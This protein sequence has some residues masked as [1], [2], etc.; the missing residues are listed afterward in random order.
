[1][2][3]NIKRLEQYGLIRRAQVRRGGGWTNT[4]YWAVYE[5]LEVAPRMG[6][7]EMAPETVTPAA[8]MAPGEISAGTSEG[9][10]GGT[11]GGALTDQS[12]NQGTELTR[13][14][15]SDR[16][17]SVIGDQSSDKD[18]GTVRIRPS[19]EADPGK[20]PLDPSRRCDRYVPTKIG[21]RICSKPAIVG[22][23]QCAEHT[24]LPSQPA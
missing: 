9:A 22:G 4:E 5:E 7:S 10:T 2:S 14:K 11:W 8:M 6:P 23:Q 1:M 20:L 21:Y 19:A 16:G 17:T 3:R 13:K 15:G 24:R 18:I 12:T